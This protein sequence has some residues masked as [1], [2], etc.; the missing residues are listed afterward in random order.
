MLVNSNFLYN[1]AL[2]F[3]QKEDS[4]NSEKKGLKKRII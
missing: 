1:F 2:G 4:I 3:E